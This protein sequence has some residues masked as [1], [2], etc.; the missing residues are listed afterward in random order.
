MTPAQAF[1]LVRERQKANE[2]AKPKPQ[3]GTITDLQHFA[4]MKRG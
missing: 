4:K 3:M 1:I 2:P